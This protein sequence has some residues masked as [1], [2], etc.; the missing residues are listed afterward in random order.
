MYFNKVFKSNQ[1]MIYGKTVVSKEKTSECERATVG[2]GGRPTCRLLTPSLTLMPD[3]REL[4]VEEILSLVFW[5]TGPDGGCTEQEGR[6]WGDGDSDTLATGA[7]NPYIGWHVKYL[8]IYN[9]E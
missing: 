2:A 8:Y 5:R 4:A 6:R 3:M 7:N 1:F 9:Q